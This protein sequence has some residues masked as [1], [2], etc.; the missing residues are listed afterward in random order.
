[1][2]NDQQVAIVSIAAI[3][4]FLILGTTVGLYFD[5]INGETYQ[6]L[7][8]SIVGTSVGG[9][10]GFLSGSKTTNNKIQEKDLTVN[11]GKILD[12]HSREMEANNGS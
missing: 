4:L 9:L 7:A 8:I 1:M 3:I 10:I 11:D 5:K 12:Y 6:T 2:K